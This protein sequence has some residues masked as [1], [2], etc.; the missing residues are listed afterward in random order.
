MTDQGNPPQLRLTNVDDASK[1]YYLK[2]EVI[3][4]TLWHRYFNMPSNISLDDYII[5]YS[6][7]LNNYTIYTRLS[8]FIDYLNYNVSTFEIKN[9]FEFPTKK[10][11]LTYYNKVI[12]IHITVTIVQVGL[13][14]IGIYQCHGAIN[15]AVLNGGII[16]IPKGHYYFT[17]SI[18]IPNNTILEGESKD[19]TAIY[20]KEESAAKKI[21]I[22]YHE[23]EVSNFAIK[24][25]RYF[26]SNYKLIKWYERFN[27]L[28]IKLS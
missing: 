5:D 25:P 13:D 15:D 24:Y 10:N 18:Q 11:N 26:C 7:S 12:M 22:C 27:I 21:T 14:I 17:S 3:H 6:N 16:Y 28:C 20:F 2:G 8:V 1:V 9:K 4:C 19:L 23:D